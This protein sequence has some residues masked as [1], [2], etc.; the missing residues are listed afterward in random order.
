MATYKASF[1]FHV[2]GLKK[3][4]P[5]TKKMVA[6]MVENE[7]RGVLGRDVVFHA[8]KTYPDLEVRRMDWMFASNSIVNFRGLSLPAV[9]LVPVR[10][11]KPDW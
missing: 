3:S 6:Y 8:S 9:L 11:K 10:Q 4:L 5:N 2:S 1:F 7:N